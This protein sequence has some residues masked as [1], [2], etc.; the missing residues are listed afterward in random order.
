MSSHRPLT[1]CLIAEVIGTFI[2]VFFGCGVVHVAVTL[3]AVSGILQA[4]LVWGL[5]VMLAVYVIGGISGG[6]INPAITLAMAIWSGFPWS[7]VAPYWVAQLA[8]AALAAACLHF[9]FSG[10]I[11]AYEAA[12]GIVRGEASSVVTASMYGEYFPNPAVGLH[13]GTAGAGNVSVIEAA[14][15]EVICTALLALC[16]FAMT[17]GGNSVAPLSNLA[18]VLIGL[19]VA[20]LIVVIGAQTQACLNPARDFGPRIVAWFA[21][22]RDVAFP[23]PRGGGATLLVY[24]I[25]PLAGGVLGGLLYTKVIGPAHHGEA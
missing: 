9:M 25:S 1:S 17:D 23:G 20:A 16:V 6:H 2:L 8:G 22:W 4:A 11:A 14:F 24:L 18:P 13:A 5:G 10:T 21:G 3:G 19:T 7:R 12:S 15:M